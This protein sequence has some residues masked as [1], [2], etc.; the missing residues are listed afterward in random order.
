[1]HPLIPI[2]NLSLFILPMIEWL[3]FVKGHKAHRRQMKG[4]GLWLLCSIFFPPHQRYPKDM[5]SW[6]LENVIHLPPTL[7]REVII[8]I[9]TQNL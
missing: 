2:S 6:D 1:M 9:N 4:T 3:E 7:S 8:P 5:V